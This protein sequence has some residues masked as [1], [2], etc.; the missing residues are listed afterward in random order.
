MALPF[1]GCTRTCFTLRTSD[2]AQIAESL[3]NHLFFGAIEP[4]G[5]IAI[6]K[7]PLDVWLQVLST[8]LF[9]FNS[10]ALK[11]PSLSVKKRAP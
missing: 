9:G 10:V 5:T 3:L 11:L 4:G 6:D 1:V 7:P 2:V 8:Q